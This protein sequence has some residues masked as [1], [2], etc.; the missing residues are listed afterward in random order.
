M[1][2]PYSLFEELLGRRLQLITPLKSNLITHIPHY[3][4]TVGSATKLPAVKT[5][6]NAAKQSLTRIILQT[7]ENHGDI[8]KGF[9]SERDAAR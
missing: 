6:A 1:N 4:L 8:S 5:A 3:N 7:I 9:F 2:C